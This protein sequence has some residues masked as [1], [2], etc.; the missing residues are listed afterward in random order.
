MIAKQPWAVG[1]GVRELDPYQALAAAI[2]AEAVKDAQ[3]ADPIK[4]VDALLFWLVDGPAW[5]AALEFDMS[6]EAVLEAAINGRV[7][8]G[9]PVED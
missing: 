3:S 7:K 6:P 1:S 9:R 4:A 2:L 8:I 5:L